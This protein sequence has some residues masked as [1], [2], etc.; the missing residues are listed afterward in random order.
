MQDIKTGRSFLLQEQLRI[1]T[2]R[3]ATA[4]VTAAPSCQLTSKVPLATVDETPY[5]L[6][7]RPPQIQ[8]LRCGRSPVQSNYSP[9]NMDE[10]LLREMEYVKKWDLSR[11]AD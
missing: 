2:Q 11:T 9:F 1:S 6:S 7:Q 10:E 4:T 5:A 3:D 8:L